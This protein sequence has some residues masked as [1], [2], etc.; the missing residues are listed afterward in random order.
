[1][2]GGLERLWKGFWE[3]GENQESVG[4]GWENVGSSQD[5]L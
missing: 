1:M 5:M 2:A 4:G 3:D